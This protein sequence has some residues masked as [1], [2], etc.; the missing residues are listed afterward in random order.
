MPRYQTWVEYASTNT[1]A[2]IALDRDIVNIWDPVKRLG[3]PEKCWFLQETIFFITA[4]F[5]TQETIIPL[6]WVVMYIHQSVR[7]VQGSDTM[8]NII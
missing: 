1:S 6:G 7:P 5:L 2:G 3:L 4:K 8:L